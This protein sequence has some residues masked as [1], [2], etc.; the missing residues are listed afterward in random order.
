VNWPFCFLILL[1]CQHFTSPQFFSTP[2]SLM[3]CSVAEGW[4]LMETNIAYGREIYQGD[5]RL[6]VHAHTTTSKSTLFVSKVASIG[7]TQSAL[8][9]SSN[10]DHCFGYSQ[11]QEFR[12]LFYHSSKREHGRKVEGG[13]KGSKWT[14]KVKLHANWTFNTGISNQK[15]TSSFM[16]IIS[17]LLLHV[18]SSM[19]VI[20]INTLQT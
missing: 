5:K 6:Q 12:M 4:L 13:S 18:H 8:C 10:E 7:S 16:P 11:N 20:Q 2:L 14:Q 19:F 3:L 17:F 1:E 15:P 9:K